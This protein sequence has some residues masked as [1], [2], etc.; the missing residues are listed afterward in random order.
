MPKC[1]LAILEVLELLM[2]APVAVQAD[3]P[4][5]QQAFASPQLW[6]YN[7]VLNDRSDFTSVI[8]HHVG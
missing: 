8:Q 1:V 6:G 7:P 4:K 5:P 3:R 2:V